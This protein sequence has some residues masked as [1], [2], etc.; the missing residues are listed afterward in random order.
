M[1]EEKFKYRRLF[2]WVIQNNLNISLMKTWQE[3]NAVQYRKILKSFLQN[4]IE[5]HKYYYPEEKMF[6]EDISCLTKEQ[7][8]T[9][10]ETVI[11]KHMAF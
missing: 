2:L 8:N 4:A 6:S 1:S 5:I 7:L 11:E 3:E 10:L 9:Y